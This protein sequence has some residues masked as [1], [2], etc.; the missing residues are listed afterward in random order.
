M[1]ITEEAGL[2][3]GYHIPLLKKLVE[4]GAPLRQEK[5][6]HRVRGETGNSRGS[7]K[8]SPQ[9]EREVLQGGYTEDSGETGLDS[10]EGQRGPGRK[11]PSPHP[12]MNP[13]C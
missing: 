4:E 6:R 11:P 13:I 8:D 9:A 1:G 3:A 10:A 2:E 5:G 12:K 7:H